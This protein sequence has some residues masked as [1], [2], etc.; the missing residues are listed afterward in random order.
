MFSA[1]MK[2]F[3]Q[4][5]TARLIYFNKLNM[6]KMK[7]LFLMM[8]EADHFRQDSSSKLIVIIT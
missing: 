7:F 4:F 2:P 3:E 6:I 1:S 8:F 5:L